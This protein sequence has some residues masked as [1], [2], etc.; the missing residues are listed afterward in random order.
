MKV[1]ILILVVIFFNS[2]SKKDK[3]NHYLNK[4]VTELELSENGFYKYSFTYTYENEEDEK[5][6]LNGKVYKYVL[7]SNVKPQ[8]QDNGRLYP[9]PLFKS[10]RNLDKTQRAEK[11]RYINDDLDNRI[12][13]YLFINDNLNFKIIYVY[14]LNIKT[15]NKLLTLQQKKVY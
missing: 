10:S 2:C 12:I 3:I 1:S 4:K 6:S 13:S 8:K 7:Y 9:A 15:K 11:L 5:D 14:S